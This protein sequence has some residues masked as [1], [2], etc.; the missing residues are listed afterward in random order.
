MP[1]RRLPN[2]DQSR[3]RALEIAFRKSNIIPP[4]S[5]AFSQ[6]SYN[7][8][9]TFLPKFNNAL[10]HYRLAFKNQATKSKE[11][12]EL[13]RKARLYISHFIQVLNMN[14]MRGDMKPIVRDFYELNDFEKCTPPLSTE[15]DLLLWG[16]KLI[17]GDHQRMLKGGNPIYNPS[18][19]LVK[20]N[21]EKFAEAYHFQKTLQTITERTW[22]NVV[23]LRAEADELIATIWNEVEEYYDNLS[24]EN[25]R[26]KASEYGVVYVFRKSELKNMPQNVSEEGILVSDPSVFSQS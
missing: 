4:Q 16:K 15:A 26:N 23:D 12:T 18:I 22:K 11:Y 8:V 7:V 24:D 5:L 25:K 13:V 19:A 10:V 2:T 6:A 20:V 21:Y 14:I 3:L 9:R 1:Y 17:D